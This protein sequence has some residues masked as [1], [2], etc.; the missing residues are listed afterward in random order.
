MF[1]GHEV[2]DVPDDEGSVEHLGLTEG[3]EIHAPHLRPDA[4][5][6]IGC[7]PDRGFI[8]DVLD[9]ALRGVVDLTLE[10]RF[11]T[12]DLR[13]WQAD[14]PFCVSIIRNRANH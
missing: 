11:A 13:P 8:A 10:H 14:A 6:V 2:H 4:F 3:S 9:T 1:R 12:Y 5:L 7:R